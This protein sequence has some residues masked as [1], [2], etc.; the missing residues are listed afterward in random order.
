MT[1][2]Y[3][4]TPYSP[5]RQPDEPAPAEEFDYLHS[6]PVQLGVGAIAITWAVGFFAYTCVAYGVDAVL[7]SVQR[8]QR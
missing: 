1:V 5:P 8:G 4:R 6:L 3:L 2:H 7:R